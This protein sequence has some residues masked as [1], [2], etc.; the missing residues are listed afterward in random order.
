MNL[1]QLVLLVGV[2]CT[3][4]A[5]SEGKMIDYVVAQV[6]NNVILKS[7]LEA[8][9]MQMEGQGYSIDE[10]TRC[11]VFEDLISKKILTHQAKLDSVTVSYDR[12]RQEVDYRIQVY[13]QKL[14]SKENMENYFN[15]EEAQIR[16][17]LAT[18]LKEMLTTQKMQKELT[19]DVSVSMPEVEQLFS[20]MPEETLPMVPEKYEYAQITRKIEPTKEDREKVKATLNA[21]RERI[22]SGDATFSALASLYSVGPSA[23]NRGEL[24]FTNRSS[25]DPEFAAVAFRLK[26]GEVSKPVKS[27]FGYHLIKMLERKGD[28]VNVQHILLRPEVSIDQISKQEK[29]LDTITNLIDESKIKFSEA[30]KYYSSDENSRLNGGVAINA[31]D[32]G[33]RF[34]KSEIDEQTMAQISKLKTGEISKAFIVEE[35]R[36]GAKELKIIKLIKII[37]AH[38]LN[39][40][41]D[42]QAVK[43]QAVQR[44]KEKVLKR[45]V[46]DKFKSTYIRV[47]NNHK[48]CPF[49]KERG[50]L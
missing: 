6:G 35:A 22:L 26:K 37:P 31:A 4:L 7:D 50:I 40:K 25:L 15:K 23:K 3:Q 38:S 20:L 42:Y 48:T 1:K 29:I 2:L 11:D 30:A 28:R 45:W 34:K 44:K 46:E 13:V 8:A 19:K 27:S 36:T 41:D 24:G 43:N 33:V 32:G 39:V 47:D 17:S 14:G 9:I 18:S 16:K 49:L 12:I 10:K 5:F 21:Y